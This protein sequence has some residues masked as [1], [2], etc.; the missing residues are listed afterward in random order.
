MT[1]KLIYNWE[2]NKSKITIVFGIN[3]KEL[4]VHIIKINAD[5]STKW[6]KSELKYLPRKW[7]K[8]KTILNNY[9]PGII[10]EIIHCQTHNVIRR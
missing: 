8:M 2:N 10:N 7:T 3:K 6:G 5:K 4:T 1:S 9:S